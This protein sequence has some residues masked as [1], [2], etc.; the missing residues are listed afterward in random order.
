MSNCMYFSP[1]RYEKR[2]YWSLHDI[3][4]PTKDSFLLGQADVVSIYAE[5]KALGYSSS[6]FNISQWKNPVYGSLFDLLVKR[7]REKLC[8]YSLEETLSNDTRYEFMAKLFMIA[9]MTA[10]KYEK[11]LSLYASQ[12]SH[13]LDGI[14]TTTSGTSRFNDTPQDGGDFSDDE[15]TTTI[16]QQSGEVLND[17]DTKMGR[18]NEIQMNYR[19]LLLDWANE[20][21][22]VFIEE[23]NI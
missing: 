15:H 1:E 12:D 3:L 11:M 16:T 21:E 2:Y 7:Y 22:S 19:N 10:P 13:L 20:F 18:I 9:E 5:M 6:L 14:S 23:D 8:L 4:A 17:G